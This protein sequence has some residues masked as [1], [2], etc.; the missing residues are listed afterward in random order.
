MYLLMCMFFII[1]FFFF[2][3]SFLSRLHVDAVMRMKK[4]ERTTQDEV[5]QC[6]KIYL[7]NA[8]DSQGGRNSRKRKADDG[9]TEQEETEDV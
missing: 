9:N 5:H 7:Q 6:I 8:G 3:S 2:F 1:S 4:M